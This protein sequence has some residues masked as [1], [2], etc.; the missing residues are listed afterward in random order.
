VKVNVEI[1]IDEE[2]LKGA[3]SSAMENYPEASTPSLQCVK[4][5]YRECYYVFEEIDDDGEVDAVHTVTLEKLMEGFEKLMQNRPRCVPPPPAQQTKE[6][7]EE[8][9]CNMDADGVDALLQFTL[10]GEIIYG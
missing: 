8:W 1:K 7:W 6:A 9:N 5:Q 3:L 4:W 2:L 10:F